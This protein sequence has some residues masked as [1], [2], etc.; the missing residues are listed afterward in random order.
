MNWYGKDE[1]KENNDYV[2]IGAVFDA[3]GTGSNFTSENIKML[4]KFYKKVKNPR[5]IL[6]IGV[7]NNQGNT[8]ATKTFLEMKKDETY[9]FGIDL[10]PKHHL[11]NDE[12]RI[13]TLEQN[14]Q[15]IEEIMT[16]VK[17]K[18]GFDH[19][20]FLFIDGWHSI[21]QC[22]M[23]WEGYTPLLA[24]GGIVGIHDTN[25]HWGPMWLFDK[26]INTYTWSTANYG[27]EPGKDFG[28]G[29]AWKRG[30]IS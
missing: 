3:I 28:I 17:Q 5:V 16:F 26:G 8:S 27:G 21:K 2:Q 4:R 29:F 22:R 6:E 24:K 25:Y 1:R 7:D 9:Y 14:S 10:E 11:D 30:E 13:F 12:K 20:D 15:F 23:E 19:I 18:S